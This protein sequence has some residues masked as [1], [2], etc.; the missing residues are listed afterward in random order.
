MRSY[1]FLF[2]RS[3][4]YFDGIP[5]RVELGIFPEAEHFLMHFFESLVCFPLRR[6]QHAD[7]IE[8]ITEPFQRQQFP[9]SRSQRLDC[10]QLRLVP[11]PDLHLGICDFSFRHTIPATAFLAR[12]RD[13]YPPRPALSSTR[14]GP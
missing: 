8:I 4:F 3:P 12:C 6:I 11:L 14:Q 7:R 13:C 5:E 1:E 2:I 10:S 9:G